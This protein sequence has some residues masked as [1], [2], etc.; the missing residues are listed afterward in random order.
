MNTLRRTS[1]AATTLLCACSGSH[2]DITIQSALDK[3]R[4]MIA[5]SSLMATQA[6]CADGP[7]R[8]QLII[9]SAELL[10]RATAGP[11]MNKLHAMMG[12]MD[13]SMAGGG[14]GGP[15]PPSAQMSQ[16]AAIHVAGGSLFDV[17]D[18]LALPTG[19]TCTQM[20]PVAVAASGA[21]LRRPPEHITDEA[22]RLLDRDMSQ[23]AGRLAGMS[24]SLDQND[25]PAV[26]G[27]VE[28]LDK[29]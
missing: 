20:Q 18:S 26:R 24:K 21:L 17:L 10:R 6:A 15:E 1:L 29:I 7:A 4:L 23:T 16:H 28:Q 25:L 3:M 27:L 19:P 13:M 14:K 9:A 12:E 5:E 11:E 22:V 8:A 2:D